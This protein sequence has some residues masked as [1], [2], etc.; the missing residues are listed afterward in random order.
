MMEYDLWQ[1]WVRKFFNDVVSLNFSEVDMLILLGEDV[2][3]CL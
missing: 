1:E 3:R 2:F